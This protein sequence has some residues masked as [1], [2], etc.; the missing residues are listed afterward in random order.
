MKNCP[1]GHQANN[2]S[3][4]QVRRQDAGNYTCVAENVANR[5]I[6]PVARLTIV[7]QSIFIVHQSG[8]KDPRNISI[9]FNFPLSA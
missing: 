9:D 4:E 2:S 7:G 5:R 8:T 3:T 1:F 6:S